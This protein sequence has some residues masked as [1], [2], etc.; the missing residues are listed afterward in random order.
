MGGCASASV[1]VHGL[2][3]RPYW[4]DV[5]AAPFDGS[6]ERAE[7]E[8]P[9][10]HGAERPTDDKTG[11]QIHDGGQIALAAPSNDNLGGVA[12]PPLDSVVLPQT[13]D[14][15]IARDGLV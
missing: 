9:I 8:V 11:M 4:T 6:L 10:V 1:P 14:R 7:R 5:G 13:G 15:A 12:D 3:A 2:A